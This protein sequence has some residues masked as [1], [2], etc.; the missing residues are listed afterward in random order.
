MALGVPPFSSDVLNGT[1]LSNMWNQWIQTLYRSLGGLQGVVPLMI[2][3][4]M[5]DA[6]VASDV[7]IGMPRGGT[8]KEVYATIG[9]TVTG[10]DETLSVFNS[11]GSSL[12]TITMTAGH[13]AGHVYK[14]QTSGNNVVGEQSFIRVNAAGTSTLL[15]PVHITAVLYIT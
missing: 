4:K 9:A 15:L 11:A 3:M 10:V 7:Y 6:S 1:K 8:V 12:G 13:T 2:N 14:L 5:D